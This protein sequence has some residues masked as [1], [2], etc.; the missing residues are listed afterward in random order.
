VITSIKRFFKIAPLFYF[1]MVFEIGRQ[2]FYGGAAVGSSRIVLNLAFTFEFIPFA[3]IVC[4]DG[5]V[6]VEMIFYAIFPV[7][8]LTIRTHR[9]ALI[10][11]IIS[12]AVS[13]YIRTALHHQHINC[14]ST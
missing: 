2:A 13:C 14:L 8:L 11:L 6:G 9:S 1:V 4:G 3:G 10:F 5:S 7:L 12:I